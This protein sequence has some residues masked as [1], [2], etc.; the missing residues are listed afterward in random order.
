MRKKVMRAMLIL[1][2]VLV[3]LFPGIGR[4]Q[5]DDP[6]SF[7]NKVAERLDSY[8][9]LNDWKASVLSTVTRVDK[10]WRPKKTTS[11][12]KV[13]EIHG[14]ESSEEILEVLEEEKGQTKDITT[15]YKQEDKERRDKAEQKRRERE[16]KGEEEE[17]SFILSEEDFFPFSEERRKSFD[18]ML[19]EES[20]AEDRPVYVLESRA[21]V[22]SDKLW[23]GRYYIDKDTFDVLKMEIMPS[24]NP[25]HVK[26][27]EMEVLFQILPGGFLILR[28][29][30]TRINAGIF[31]KRIRMIIEEEFSD[32]EVLP[33]YP[34]EGDS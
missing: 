6:E 4:V 9:D 22:K 10:N 29:T 18:F 14:E 31:I 19:L 12:R 2:G 26:E 25:K 32:Y 27:L 5:Q 34:Q 17:G 16:E 15:K 8:P 30:K 13:I 20:L 7:L 1:A 11:V 33:A 23:E 24:K 21:K 28:K 3:V